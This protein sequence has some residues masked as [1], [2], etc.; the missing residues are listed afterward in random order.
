MTNVAFILK[1]WN[2]VSLN[3]IGLLLV[4]KKHADTG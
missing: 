2:I 3:K 1:I 4:K